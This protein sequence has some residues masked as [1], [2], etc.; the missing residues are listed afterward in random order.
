M[1]SERFK[2]GFLVIGVQK[3]GTTE[4]QRILRQHR[5]LGLASR[6]EVHYFD[7]EAFFRSGRDGD[8]AWYHSFFD[9]GAD[10]LLHGENTPAYLYWNG[11]PERIR[12]YNPAVRMIAVLRNPIERAYSHWS[13][14]RRLG[15]ETLPFWEAL[16][17]ESERA[18]AALPF[19]D[20]RFSY[21]DRGFYARQLER[22]GGFFPREQVLVLRHEGLRNNPEAAC[23]RV[24]EF[25]GV[26]RL[27]R[28]R[29][30]RRPRPVHPVEMAAR[31]REYLAEVFESEIRALERL[32]GW[33]CKAWL[34]TPAAVEG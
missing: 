4:L 22:Y 25:L 29:R 27:P 19:Q 5:Q 13:M 17:N 18:R 10:V 3:G 7:N 28:I 32:L 20:H 14:M 15:E 9:A 26:E 34:D 6:K 12:R 21:V 8:E 31:E 1:E 23:D 2:V 11:A 16:R 33:D 24:W 30:K